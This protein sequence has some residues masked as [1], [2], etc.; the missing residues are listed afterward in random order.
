MRVEFIPE[1]QKTWELF[2]LN[3]VNQSGHGMLGFQ[4][5]RYQRG[6]GIGNFF[7][8]LLRSILPM[9]KSAGKA[10]G[11]QALHTGLNVASDALSGRNVGESFEEHAKTGT[12]NLLSKAE[13]RLN[14]K[15]QQEGSGLGFRSVTNTQMKRLINSKPV[16]RK[17]RL[18]KSKPV[19]RNKRQRKDQLGI[20]YA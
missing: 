7:G 18:I 8:G 1:D 12:R 4:G 5:T 16:I 10:I 11:K 14:K 15:P 2:F 20:Y 19:I 6:A 17:K 3:D 9:V 13:V